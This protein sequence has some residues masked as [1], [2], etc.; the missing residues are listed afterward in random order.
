MVE[1]I[2]NE[3][4]EYNQAAG[5]TNDYRKIVLDGIP[6]TIHE[7]I[8]NFISANGGG[9]AAYTLMKKITKLCLNRDRVLEYARSL[10]DRKAEGLPEGFGHL[11]T[12]ESVKKSGILIIPDLGYFGEGSELGIRDS[13]R[14]SRI[15]MHC[16][17]GIRSS[18]LKTSAATAYTIWNIV[19]PADVL[20]RKH[21]TELKIAVSP[22]TKYSFLDTS[23]EKF[24]NDN[25]EIENIVTVNSITDK[26]RLNNRLR[27]VFEKA[28]SCK[29]DILLFC[30]MYGTEKLIRDP[31]KI[32]GSD[33]GRL[34]L[35]VLP[36]WWHDGK[37]E[38][39]VL[40]SSFTELFCQSKKYAAYF[41]Q[42]DKQKPKNRE[43]LQGREKTIYIY[44][45]PDIGRIV[46]TICMDFLTNPYRQLIS[47]ILDASFILVPAY[48]RGEADFANCLDGL[49][50]YGCYGV[51]I[52]SCAALP[53]EKRKDFQESDYIGK[54]ITP[55]KKIPGGI[56]TE[57]FLIPECGTN[58]GGDADPCLF[59][60]TITDKGALKAEHL[61][62]FKE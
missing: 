21:L 22:I 44:H 40:D 23:E 19:P 9:A 1:A 42:D 4:Q 13:D 41:K 59:L 34:S 53:N 31:E 25:G 16:L 35:I 56:D 7:K 33:S 5:D 6:F 27:A 46:V 32:L 37:N 20:P 29:A 38:A 51:F 10:V 54:V 58:C 45:W 28:V 24:I 17:I 50:P 12:E 2:V 47:K 14:L 60:I 48:S 43:G 61:C 26:E 8:S 18:D 39:H 15:Q 11:N 3:I 52:N 36:S 57:A 55:W 30:E 49:R 62:A